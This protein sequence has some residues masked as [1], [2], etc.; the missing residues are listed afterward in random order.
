MRQNKGKTKRVP[1]IFDIINLREKDILNTIRKFSKN[2]NR[3]PY[4]GS[5]KV[6]KFGK[7][8]TDDIKIQRYYCKECHRT[9]NELSG[10]PLEGV[11][12]IKNAL[13]VAYFK[14]ELKCSDYAISKALDIPYPTV[15]YLSNKINNNTK[16]FKSLLVLIRSA[17]SL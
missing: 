17:T 5:T 2:P 12:S 15:R 4:C 7:L 14:L 6:V 10:T 3:C 8:R 11:H 16:F 9:F 1:T 13:L